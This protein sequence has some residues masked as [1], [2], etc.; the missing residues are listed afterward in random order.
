MLGNTID[1]SGLETVA[2]MLG[3]TD[4]EMLI[5]DLMTI[6]DNL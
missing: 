1:W 3:V 5:Y 2:T 4:V 6:R